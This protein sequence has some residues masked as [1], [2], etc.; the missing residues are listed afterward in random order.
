MLYRR[1]FCALVIVLV[2]MGLVAIVAAQ[3]EAQA[4]TEAADVAATM[5]PEAA[6]D[7]DDCTIG[8]VHVGPINDRGWSE[9]H[10]VGLQ[11]ASEATGWEY[12]W[13]ESVVPGFTAITTLDAVTDLVENEGACIIFLTSDEFEEDTLRIA[14]DFP[15]VKFVSVTADT[16]FTGEAPENVGNGNGVFEYSRELGGY[17]AGVV[18]ASLADPA[19]PDALDVCF[20]G[21]LRNYETERH[22]NSFILAA[23]QGWV[24][25]GMDPADFDFLS[26]FIGFWFQTPDTLVPAEVVNTFFDL[27][28][29]V[30][31]SGIDTTEAL[32]V[33]QLRSTPDNPRFAVMTDSPLACEEAPE[34]A[35]ISMIYNWHPMYIDN[36]VAVQ[37]GTWTSQF[38]WRLPTPDDPENSPVWY[39]ECGG[40]TEEWSNTLNAFAV[41]ITDFLADPA[42]DGCIMLWD[43]PLF[44]EDDTPLVNESG[45]PYGD[46]ECIPGILPEGSADSIWFSSQPLS[47]QKLAERYA[48]DG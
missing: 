24:D 11:I 40:M 4:T 47:V 16:V 3:T 26:S 31:A 23:M 7:T 33:T 17:I 34:F 1:M 25:A 39:V 9:N 28:C 6:Q 38:D 12:F 10:H 48:E 5:V 15:D 20:L 8:A 19:N 13:V 14:L 35:L 46:G 41:R 2:L 32:S 44:Y 43:G 22:M 18:A 30:V 37:E 27:G 45:V 29:L 21:P 42:N 36:V